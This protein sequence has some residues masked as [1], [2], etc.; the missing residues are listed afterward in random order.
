MSNTEKLDFEI[1]DPALKMIKEAFVRQGVYEYILRFG[2]NGTKD[3]ILTYYFFSIEKEDFNAEADLE[4]VRGGVNCIFTKDLL[5]NF[6]SVT[7]DCRSND[8]GEVV[9]FFSKKVP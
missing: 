7:L 8:R 3:T 4:V 5:H 2:C 9:F 6:N 1:T